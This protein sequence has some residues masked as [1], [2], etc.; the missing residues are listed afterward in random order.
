MSTNGQ[1]EEG[2][3]RCSTHESFGDFYEGDL[4]PVQYSRYCCYEVK[5]PTDCLESGQTNAHQHNAHLKQIC[6]K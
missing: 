2:D 5:K 4:F 3:P 6:V 1:T